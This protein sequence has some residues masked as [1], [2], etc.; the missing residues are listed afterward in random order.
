ALLRWLL[1]ANP[2]ALP[3]GT[4]VSLNGGVLAF[5]LVVAVATA[6]AFGL[7]PSLRLSATEPGTAVGSTRGAAPGVRRGPWPYL[8]ATEVAL[9]LVLLVGSGLL[10]RSFWTVLSGNPGYRTDAVLAV[11]VSLPQ[12]VY[13]EQRDVST[14]LQ[15]LR[16]TLAALPGVAGVGG[17]T[18]LPLATSGMNGAIQLEGQADWD[19]YGEYRVVLPGYFQAMG[20]RLVEG[21]VFGDRDRYGAAQVAVVNQAMADRFWPG[22]DPIGK[23]LR[24][25]TNDRYPDWLTVVGVVGD[26]R[27]RSLTADPRPEL[28]VDAIQRP[29][30][31]R[32][33]TFTLYA[34][35]D[36]GLVAGPARAAMHQA[37]PEAAVTTATMRSIASRSVADRRFT[38]LLLGVFA[39]VALALAG[40]GIY[41]VVGY[42][43]ARRTREIGIRLA[44]GA[45]PGRVLRMVQRGMLAAVGIG[46]L[47]GIGA[48]LGLTRLLSGLLYGVAPL[49]PATFVAV[50][51]LV[52][53]AA[54]LASYLPARRAAA[55]DPMRTM[56][57]Q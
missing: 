46:A 29:A 27:Q 44:L 26:V 3:D 47:V 53:A 37:A 11:N 51:F 4:T 28:Y 55:V 16:S 24:G 14:T 19:A 40:A 6:L 12:S 23:R 25:T 10:L 32:E 30:R 17:T 31:A 36:P 22:E 45:E 1:A 54:W 49:D 7:L 38:L 56:R 43:V 2:A 41:G 8:V 9:A 48:A 21:R 39:A 35:G 15:R 33:M 5:T 50:A 20:I 18:T 34:A 52:L 57:E 13:P 42:T